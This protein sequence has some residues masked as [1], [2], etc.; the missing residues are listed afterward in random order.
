[1]AQQLHQQPARVAAGA[2]GLGQRLLGRLHARL[3]ADQVA[4]VALQALVQADQ[5]VD[6]ALL[7]A[8]DA[9]QVAAEGRR[10][11]VLGQVGGEF[12]LQQRRVVE[13]EVLGL[14][15][16]EEVEGVE[17]RHLGDQVNADLE[18]AGRLGEHQP[19]LPVG[20][21][22]LL[23][24]DEVLRGFDLERIRNDLAAAV[25]RRPQTHDLRAQL[26]RAVVAVMGG[27]LQRSVNRHEGFLTV[28]GP[29]G[30]LHPSKM[31]A[32]KVSMALGLNRIFLVK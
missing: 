17:H 2:A 25:R 12:F 27:V 13:G 5:E 16:Q 29:S 8:L 15:L 32:K 30:T 18:H 7:S 1:M 21:R 24:V 11:R 19:R 26:D 6:G 31:R 4:D 28:T 20:E 3:H 23:P 14:G 9:L 10:R 22:V